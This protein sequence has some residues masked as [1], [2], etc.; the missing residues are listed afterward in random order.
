MREQIEIGKTIKLR[1][2][3]LDWDNAQYDPTTVKISIW[4]NKA[5]KKVDAQTATR[6]AT[7]H[8]YY[9]YTIPDDETVEVVEQWTY[10][11]DGQTGDSHSL[12]RGYFTVVNKLITTDYTTV[13]D[14]EI[15]LQQDIDD[16]TTPSMQEVVRLIKKKEAL[17]DNLCDTAWREKTVTEEFHYQRENP[18]GSW[19]IYFNL[20][21]TPVRELTALKIRNWGFQWIDYFA[22]E[23]TWALDENSLR[24]NRF[25]TMG[26]RWRSLKISYTYGETEVPEDISELCAKLVLLDLLRAE[27]YANL[28]PSG[29]NGVLNLAFVY[30]N[31]QSDINRILDRYRKIKLT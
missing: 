7:G 5:V 19:W 21:K 28:L 16:T 12:D 3:F 20:K 26:L 30:D 10:V 23:N 14:I 8:Y 22:R 17:I 27:R 1:A 6:Q 18:V 13:L 24:I 25:F 4:N 29:V 2:E 9:D 15:L 11:F 31:L